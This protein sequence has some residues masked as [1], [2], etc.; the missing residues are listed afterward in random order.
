[1]NCFYIFLCCSSSF[2][3]TPALALLMYCG[4][5]EVTVEFE[6]FY[7]NSERV[8]LSELQF[9]ECRGMG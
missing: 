4:A 5:D 9:T 3:C 6:C 2:V 7:S 8:T 1:M